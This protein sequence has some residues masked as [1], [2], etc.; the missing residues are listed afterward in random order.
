MF[1]MISL[2][3]RRERGTMLR[4]PF[5]WFHRE[6]APLFERAFPVLP[7][8]ARYSPEWGFETEELENEYV[9]RAAVPGF[10]ASE[11]EVTLAGNVLTLRAEPRRPEK[12][13]AL[14]RPYA[15]L[16]R[17]LT[18]PPGLNLEAVEARYHNGILEVHVPRMP[19]VLPRRI[20]VKA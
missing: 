8:E 2:V 18:L 17:A 3:P 20:E 12:E 19:E 13:P 15:R 5:E 14:E 1:S 9:V 16:E 7:F 11:L 4:N 6:F 10:E